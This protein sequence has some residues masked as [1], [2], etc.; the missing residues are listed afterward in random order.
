MRRRMSRVEETQNWAGLSFTPMFAGVAIMAK[1]PELVEVGICTHDGTYSTDY[2]IHQL[3]IPPDAPRSEKERI[4]QK[5]VLK[6]LKN[7]S[8]E[9]CL[10][11][12]GAGVTEKSLE[13]TPGLPSAMWRDMDI[14]TMVYKVQH[15]APKYGLG[16]EEDWELRSDI[17]ALANSGGVD[18]IISDMASGERIPIDVD[19]QAD[20]AAR[21]CTKDFGPG[22]NPALCIG[23]RNQVDID[24]GGR[25]RLVSNMEEYKGTVMSDGT[26]NTTMKFA[27]DLRTRKIKMAFFSSTPQGGGV[28]LMRHALLRFMRMS[29]V[30][31]NW[32]VPKPNPRV[33]RITKTNHNILQGVA[34]PNVRLTDQQKHLI[35]EWITYNAQ[36]SWLSPGGPLAKGGADVVIIDDPQMP[37]LI[38]LIK[39]ARPEVPVIYRSHIEIRSDLVAIDGSPQQEVWSYLWD[40]IKFADIFISHPMESFVPD[41]VPLGKV[42]LMPACTDWLDGLNKVLREWDLRYYHHNFRTMCTDIHMS[43]LQYPQRDY[44]I[45]VA[46]FD[47]SKGIP[48]VIDAFCRLRKRL[49]EE[50]PFRRTPQLLIC[51]HG[52][53]DDPDASIIYD[54]TMKLLEQ[55][56]YAHCANDIIVMRIGPSDQMLNAL[57]TNAKIALQLSTREGFE[58][59]VSEA[60]HHGKPVVATRAGG[61]PLQLQH[62]KNGYLVQPGDTQSVADYLYDLWTDP[63]LYRRISDYARTSVSDE[64]GT[65]GNALCWLYLVSKL[66]RERGW[67]PRAKWINDL[68]REEAGQPYEEGETK[69]PRAVFVK[70]KLGEDEGIVVG[71]GE[72]IPVK[73]SEV[74]EEVEPSEEVRQRE[75]LELRKEVGV[76]AGA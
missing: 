43:K 3:K 32:Y 27:K 49:D 55:E 52:A 66:T 54:E 14:V 10:K 64:V 72:E 70:R 1:S 59:K 58:V 22:G 44:I 41:V 73:I 11:F 76:G 61:I 46:R 4:V 47:P 65:V 39:K 56:P 20:S 19:E 62:G 45:Q 7:F 74:K 29:G 37:G 6:Q 75:E 23:F 13:V 18:G 21:K 42:G 51:G 24:S 15:T 60:L 57:L 53:V 8:D 33:F 67:R 68:A 36:R 48:D 2:C 50:L 16:L 5:H 38:P 25:V 17:S 30:H 35:D 40:K 31:A 71:T 69:L 34:G 63:A 9:H 12:V 28:A 26:W